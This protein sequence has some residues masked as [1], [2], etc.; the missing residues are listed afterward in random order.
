MKS[1]SLDFI[2]WN[3]ILKFQSNKREKSLV[4]CSQTNNS[5]TQMKHDLKKE[6]KK[7]DRTLYLHFMKY[8]THKNTQGTLS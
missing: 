1:H 2:Y 6:K 7:K 8:K 5:E 4:I 3:I